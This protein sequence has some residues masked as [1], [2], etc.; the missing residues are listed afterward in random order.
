MWVILWLVFKF[1]NNGFMGFVGLVKFGKIL[2]GVE[3][4]KREKFNVE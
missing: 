4:K 1:G 2:D 3:G